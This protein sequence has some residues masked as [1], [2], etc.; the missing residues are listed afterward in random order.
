LAESQETEIVTDLC[1]V[2]AGPAGISIARTLA[3]SGV[4]I[5][6]LE[7][8]GVNVE[9]RVQQLSRGE[10]DG[11]PRHP[12][13]QSRV[14][15]FG[16]TLRHRRLLNGGWAARPLDP[17]DF[18]SRFGRAEFGWPFDRDHLIPY[19]VRAQRD[20][21][22]A[23]YDLVNGNPTAD[24]RPAPP[25]QETTDLESALFQFS[26]A[27]FHDALPTFTNSPDVRLL[28]HCRVADITTDPSGRRVDAITAVGADRSRVVVRPRLVVLATGGIENARLLLTANS[29]RGLGNEHDLVGRYFAERMSLPV[30]HVV[31]SGS[32]TVDDAGF[33]SRLNGASGALRISESVQ[34]DKD[35]LNCAFFLVPWP[36]AFA[37][38]ALRSLYTLHKAIGRRPRIDG[39]G[40]HLREI[41]TGLPDVVDMALST[42]MSRPRTLLLRAQGEHAPNSQSRVSLGA[43]RDDLGIPVARVTWRP[44]DDDHHSVRTSVGIL[45]AVFRSSGFGYVETLFDEVPATL[46]EGNHHHMG[47]TRMNVD[48]RKGVVDADS[49][50]HSVEN[51]YIAGAS[52]F[53]TY[54]ASNPTLT[55]VALALRLADHLG[56][57]LG[58]RG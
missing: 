56:G 3:G 32:H 48:P 6:L 50:V 52:V 29:G 47:T 58:S 7:S 26:T 17:I 25:V 55:I 45:D 23:P 57:V 40:T 38:P 39:V 13:Q 11:N 37:T 49:R 41:V 21:G 51:L 20:C 36:A 5:C 1:I 15:A 14:R 28:L 31:L 18:E 12:L 2:G 35:L 10:S 30:G 54:G 22:L 42:V 43:G 4:R 19:Y 33:F 53:P 27:D 16:G 44:T 34:R 9:R 46:V 8:G 24:G